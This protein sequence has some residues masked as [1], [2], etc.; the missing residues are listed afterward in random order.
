MEAGFPVLIAFA[1]KHVTKS[2]FFAENRFLSPLW[3]TF[4]HILDQLR[5]L[6]KGKFQQILQKEG[7][8]RAGCQKYNG[9]GRNRICLQPVVLPWLIQVALDVLVKTGEL[10]QDVR[11]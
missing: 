2:V 7:V 9:C 6:S 1:L 4:V 11:Y 8:S 5:G 3:T 10:R